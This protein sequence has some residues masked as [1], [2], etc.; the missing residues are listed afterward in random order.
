MTKRPF[1]SI[2]IP[3][4]NRAK[5]LQFALF[6]IL[7][8]SFSNFEVIIS[9]NCSKDNTREIIEKCKD[10]RVKYFR[11][12]TNVTYLLN[13]KNALR[14]A[15]GKYVFFHADDD[16]LLKKASLEEIFSILN[17]NNVG[18]ARVN[19]LCLTPDKKNIFD[20]N[21]SKPLKKDKQIPKQSTN[22]KINSFIFDT[23]ATF[24]SGIVFK[25]Y[26]PKQVKVIDSGLMP[27]VDI[28]FYNI[29]NYGGYFISKPHI[30]ASWSEWVMRKNEPHHLYS[31][32]NGKLAYEA[33]YDYIQSKLAPME[34][35]KFLRSRL[36]KSFILILPAIKVYVGQKDM[37][38]V[39]KRIKILDPEIDKNYTYWI[40]YLSA[41]IIPRPILKIM[42]YYYFKLYV[43]SLKIQDKK[44]MQKL[45]NLYQDY[46]PILKTR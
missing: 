41:S 24:T 37:Q 29:K 43:K 33:Q 6:C 26:W 10:K 7:K 3:T 35:K 27:W 40:F 28:L 15:R 8:Q 5:D 13:V 44:I 20:F 11:S 32:Q 34:Y 18:Y 1:F 46:Q 19:Y 36:M 22:S 30:I 16:F 12:K 9:D 45:Q 42:K 17:K 25:N 21:I 14:H 39:I 38:K 2:I 23:D 4:Y 31:L